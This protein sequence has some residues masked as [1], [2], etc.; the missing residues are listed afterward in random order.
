MLIGSGC[1]S[2][3]DDPS[4]TWSYGFGAVTAVCAA[5]AFDSV[6]A[7]MMVVP[8]SQPCL[9]WSGTLKQL[10]S[11]TPEAKGLFGEKKT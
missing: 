8:P 4:Q 7:R 9:S 11:E 2:S 6:V 10:F 3:S 5:F 1:E